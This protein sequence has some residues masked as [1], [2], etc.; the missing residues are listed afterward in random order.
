M[1]ISVCSFASLLCLNSKFPVFFTQT[2]NPLN[3]RTTTVTMSGKSQRAAPR[4]AKK[5]SEEAPL[6]LEKSY[7]MVDTV[8]KLHYLPVPAVA[9]LVDE[10]EQ[11]YG[12]PYLC[13]AHVGPLCAC[14]LVDCF[15]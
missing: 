15:C 13:S 10:E 9:M 5:S 8:I 6:F 1:A 2:P 4:K 3:D 14:A 12:S 7:Q 11:R